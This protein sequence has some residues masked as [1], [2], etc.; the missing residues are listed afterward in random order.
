MVSDFFGAIEPLF[1]RNSQFNPES[2]GHRLGFLH[3]RG[4]KLAGLCALYDFNES[5]AGERADRIVGH[6]THQLDPHVMPNVCANR[7]AQSGFDES[8]GNHS[9]TLAL[10]SVGLANGEARPL[11]ML[12]DSRL[13]DY[14]RRIDDAADH[15]RGIYALGNDS[16][17]IY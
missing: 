9:A 15:A 6:V 14:R 17:G 11:D 13:G 8:I 16:T 5:R 10:R 3:D 1:D 12:D 2:L 7:T 4:R